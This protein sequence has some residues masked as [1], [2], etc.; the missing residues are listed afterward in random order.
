LTARR[1]TPSL[2]VSTKFAFLPGRLDHREFLHDGSG[3]PRPDLVESMLED[4]RQEGS[5]VVY[6]ETFEEKRLEEL[7][8]AFPGRADRLQG[9]IDRL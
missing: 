3:D 2:A 7:R 4:V 9:M 5:I 8:D 6:H 1:R